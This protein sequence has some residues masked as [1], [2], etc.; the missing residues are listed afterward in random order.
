MPHWKDHNF[1]NYPPKDWAEVVPKLD[2]IGLDLLKVL[3]VFINVENAPTKPSQSNH[4]QGC[5]N[6]SLFQRS[7][8]RS[9]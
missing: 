6:P 3:Y 4:R 9:P 7:P 8:L 2:E 1:E 5:L